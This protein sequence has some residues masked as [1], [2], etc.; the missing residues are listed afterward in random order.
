MPLLGLRPALS[1]DA[2]I[3][4]DSHLVKI[5]YQA[6]SSWGRKRTS[7]AFCDGPSPAPSLWASISTGASSELGPPDLLRLTSLAGGP[8]PFNH[9]FVLGHGYT[10]SH[11]LPVRVGREVEPSLK[12][13]V[14]GRA[15]PREL[16]EAELSCWGTLSGAWAVFVGWA[17]P[18]SSGWSFVLA[19]LGHVI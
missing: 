13:R 5:F 3:F 10:R 8:S 1:R 19:R 2:V 15:F 12:G 11:F 17:I 18:G 9:P 7:R 4:K 6:V 14:R 16:G